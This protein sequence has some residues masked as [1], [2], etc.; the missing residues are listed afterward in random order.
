MIQNKTGWLTLF[1]CTAFLLTMLG[2]CG[3]DEDTTSET[4]LCA[5]QTSKSFVRPFEVDAGEYPF[6]S[7]AFQTGRGRMHFF[8]EGPR[9]AKETILMIHG[10]PTWSFL[11]RNIA[12]DMIAKGHRVIAVDHLGMGMSDAPELAEFDYLPRSHSANLETFVKAMDLKNVTLVVQDWG[13]PV[14]LGMA[15]RQPQRIG[16]VMVMNTWAWSANQANPGLDHGLLNWGQQATALSK[17]DPQFGCNTMLTLTAEQLGMFYDPSK[18]ARYKM[19][20]NAYLQPAIDPTTMKPLSARKCAA[21]SSFALA[22]LAD[23]AYQGEVEAAL[24]KLQGKPYVV[25]SGLSDQLFGALRCNPAASSPCPGIS[26]C[27]CDPA[28]ALAGECGAPSTSAVRFDFMCKAGG[29]LIEQNADQWVRRMGTSSLWA[30]YAVPGA[31]HMVQE[32]ARDQVIA[33]LDKLLTAPQR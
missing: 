2:G 30:R 9:D 5:S 1:A 3:G 12:K 15:T 7:C 21:M 29:S 8:D 10:N 27:E 16:R 18:G 20:R 25:L 28:Y 6:K 26:V 19:I 22:I 32:L 4:A 17:A 33:G 31:E 23:N 11:Y 13:G 24:P 14:G